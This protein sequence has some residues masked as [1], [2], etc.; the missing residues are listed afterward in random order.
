MER[1]WKMDLAGSASIW[2][3]LT[4]TAIALLLI[5]F[6]QASA[7]QGDPPPD[8]QQVRQL[9]NAG[10]WREVV[11]LVESAPNR[12]GDLDFCYGE[13]LAHLERWDDA[14]RAFE[15]GWRLLPGDKRFPTE[16]AGVAFKQRKY[17]LAKKDLQHA[18]ELDPSD[19]Y[20]NDFLG[21]IYFLEDNAEAALKYWNRE[22]RPQIAAVRHDPEPNVDPE[23]LDRAFLFSPASVL[24]L[25]E[26]Q[27]TQAR[28]AELGIFPTARFDLEAREDGK[29]DLLFR[30][31][32][33]DGW[34]SS[35]WQALFGI[36]RG[37]PFQTVYPEFYN[38]HRQAI[39]V[40]S[41]FRWDAQKRRAM[42]SISGPLQQ[43][44]KWRYGIT[45]DLRGENWNVVNSFT[46][47]AQ[48]FGSLNLRREGLGAE[49]DSV[50]S[51][52]WSWSAGAELSHRDFRNV[53]EGSALNSSLLAKGYQLK[54][55]G[56]VSVAI[57]RIPER[58]FTLTASGSYDLGRLW[59]QAG[60]SFLKLQPEA[61]LDWFPQAEG[62][63]YQV[64]GQVRSGK[65]FGDVPFD[66]LFMLGVERDNDLWMR[67]HVG[68]RDGRKGSAPLGRNYFLSNWGFDKNVYGNG[69]VDI[70]LGP[71]LDSGKITDPTPGLGSHQ[72]L[73]DTGVQAKVRLLGVGVGFSYGKDLRSG[74][75]AFYVTM[76]R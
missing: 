62:D 59:S 2:S 24:K 37:L 14:R 55:T 26:L 6:S 46:G 54:Q 20:I 36:F 74:S 38:L 61:R 57:W 18:L 40:V 15:A 75:N 45:A 66:E 71:F 35:K 65:T 58:R 34:G 29:F 3:P 25:G 50:E 67:A 47:V 44:P 9:L 16:L 68:T 23:L 64:Q 39:N 56:E 48:S 7:A 28:V 30:N 51:G 17:A 27:G 12:S 21:T 10:K 32:E 11:N 5:L 49:V 70:K 4:R 41:L 33:R 13:A 69:L 60:E 19:S 52:R 42:A 63:D 73:W 76:G 1:R 31:R 22:G 72:W 43:N 53:V 8:A